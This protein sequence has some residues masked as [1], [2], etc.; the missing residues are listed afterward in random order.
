MPSARAPH[1]GH[2]LLEIQRGEQAYPFTRAEITTADCKY[3]SRYVPGLAKARYILKVPAET[4]IRVI[5]PALR[6]VKLRRVTRIGA[7]LLARRQKDRALSISFGNGVRLIPLISGAGPEGKELRK[8]LK[9]IS[10]WGFT[11]TSDS[12]QSTPG[13]FEELDPPS[14]KVPTAA[15]SSAAHPDF[16]IVLHLYY[17][18]LWPEFEKK[19]LEI[20]APFHL[21]V[22]TTKHDSTFETAILATFPAAEIFVYENRG[23]DVGPF[24][25]LLHE[26]HLDR[27]RLI[28][29]LHGKRSGESGPRALFGIVWRRANIAD[30]IGSNETVNEILNRFAT[31]RELAVVGSAHFRLPNQYIGEEAAWANNREMTLELAQRMGIP[32]PDFKL[33]FFAGTMFWIRQDALTPIRKLG[34]TINDFANETGAVDGELAHAVERIF[35]A[36]RLLQSHTA[37][38]DKMKAKSHRLL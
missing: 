25:Q 36:G 5:S 21:I 34:L 6:R 37:I 1:A 27:F 12:L 28:C 2:Y 16:A 3:T 17:Q 38:P 20:S 22:T 30:L 35:G 11:L 24:L 19:L 33:D 14:T 8:A 29:K 10:N 15:E 18:Q 4:E 7:A 9:L 13:L 31:T 32:K 23:R 26:G